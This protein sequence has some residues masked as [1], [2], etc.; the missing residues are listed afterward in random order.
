[1]RYLG[2]ILFILCHTNSTKANILNV[3]KSH[4]YYSIQTAIDVAQAGDTIQVS[5]GTYTG[6]IQVQKS[7]VLIGID[8]P[9]LDGENKIEN[10]VVQGKNVSISGFIIKDSKKSSSNDYAAISVIDAENILIKNNRIENAH[11][12]IHIANSRNCNL[13]QNIITGL[14]QSKALAMA[15]ISG[16]PI[17]LSLKKI[18]F[19]VIVMAFTSN[20]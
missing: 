5:A 9:V 8:F 16:N 7:I 4:K 6:I 17:T 12:G 2:F 14:L 3:G 19:K 13:Y 20:L 11:F 10:I 1:M 18:L 15:S